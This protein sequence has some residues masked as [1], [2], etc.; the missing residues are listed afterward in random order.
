[1]KVIAVVSAK[2]GV[3]KST[4]ARAI[5]VHAASSASGQGGRRVAL[6]DLD[7]QRTLEQWW[8]RRATSRQEPASGRNPDLLRN[9]S[10]AADAVASLR[11]CNSYDLAILD[12]PPSFLHEM[13]EALEAS[14]I[15]LVP[16][17][18]DL[19]NISAT[20]DAIVLARK[21]ACKYLV[22]INRA[23]PRSDRGETI[24]RVLRDGGQPVAETIMKDTITWSQAHD[25]GLSAIEV[26]SASGR[27]ARRQV[28]AL[29]DEVQTLLA[30]AAPEVLH[31]R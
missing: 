30:A 10:S 23:P 28:A 8:D 14:D 31:G 24:Q 12:L 29:W 4:L 7:P 25:A 16:L 17:L 18:P 3:G 19:D 26:S 27:E 6:V 15:A 1:M 13:Q 2:G 22:V 20:R 11:A 21:A 5:A 9:A